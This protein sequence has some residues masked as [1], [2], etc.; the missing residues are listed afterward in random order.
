[1]KPDEIVA[2]GIPAQPAPVVTSI[3]PMQSIGYQRPED[4]PLKIEIKLDLDGIVREATAR[5]TQNDSE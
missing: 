2:L 5:D 1:L 4:D 3:E